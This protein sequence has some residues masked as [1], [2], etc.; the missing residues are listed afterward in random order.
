MFKKILYTGCLCALGALASCSGN[1]ADETAVPANDTVVEGVIMET[2]DHD[3][4]Q[5]EA[6]VGEAVTTTEE[7][8]Q[9]VGKEAK[10]AGTVAAEEVKEKGKE[11]VDKAKEKG[12]DAA[13][14]ALDKAKEAVNK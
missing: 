3:G 4:Q 1:K 2:V 14:K 9:K 5:M 12:K 8:F 11:V 10:E 6:E 7:A 13:N